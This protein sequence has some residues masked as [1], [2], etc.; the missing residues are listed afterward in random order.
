MNRNEVFGPPWDAPIYDEAVEDGAVAETP[1][2]QP[3]NWCQEPIVEG[4][5]GIML[6]AWDVSGKAKRVPL[7]KECE[8]RS[9]LGSLGHMMRKCSCYVT[10]KRLAVDDPPH[11]TRREAAKAA[12]DFFYSGEWVKLN[13]PGKA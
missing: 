10:D 13:R 9:V 7:H 5:S 3:C 11:L 12:W 2:G 1:I 8:L 4:D 6:T